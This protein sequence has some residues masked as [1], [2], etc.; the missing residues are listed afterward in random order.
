MN[1]NE[2]FFVLDEMVLLVCFVTASARFAQLWRAR[3]AQAARCKINK[4]PFLRL[5][6]IFLGQK[7]D[8]LTVCLVYHPIT[9]GVDLWEDTARKRIM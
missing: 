6:F 2:V 9:Q 7:Y 1:N 5:F 3:T 8:C 4:W